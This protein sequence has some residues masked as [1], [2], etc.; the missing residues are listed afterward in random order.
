MEFEM[1]EDF[2]N[3][4]DMTLVVTDE[5]GA[6]EMMRQSPQKSTMRMLLEETELMTWNKH[7]PSSCFTNSTQFTKRH[8]SICDVISIKSLLSDDFSQSGKCNWYT[9]KT[10]FFHVPMVMAFQV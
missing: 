9:T 6:L 2:L 8:A 5:S 1:P 7:W 10:T 3:Q 4:D